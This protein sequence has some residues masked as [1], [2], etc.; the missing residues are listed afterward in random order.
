MNYTTYKIKSKIKTIT[1]MVADTFFDIVFFIPRYFYKNSLK[2]RTYIKNSQDIL[3]KLDYKK[4]II[5]NILK[6]IEL[7]IY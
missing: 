1:E 4:N 6:N 7:Y 2:F 3:I 5:S